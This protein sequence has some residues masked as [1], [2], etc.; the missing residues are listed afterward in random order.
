MRTSR[1]VSFIGRRKKEEGRRKKEEGR[2][3]KEEGRGKREEVGG[4]Y[5]VVVGGRCSAVDGGVRK[6]LSPKTYHLQTT[7]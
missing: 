7:H 3:K 2:R 1:T 4:R 5:L 6:N